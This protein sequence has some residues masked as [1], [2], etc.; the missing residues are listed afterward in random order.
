MCEYVYR[1]LD[2][3]AHRPYTASGVFIDPAVEL[4]DTVSI[5]GFGEAV[6]FTADIRLGGDAVW[7]ISLPGESVIEHEFPTAG[8]YSR[9]LERKVTLGQPYEGVTISRADGI[10]VQYTDGSAE[11]Q[12]K[13]GFTKRLKHW[14]W[15]MTIV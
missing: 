2:G 6:L 7:D 11:A 13:S 14:F 12:L 9:E 15:S 5:H 10:T 3:Y 4:G 8:Q 1:R